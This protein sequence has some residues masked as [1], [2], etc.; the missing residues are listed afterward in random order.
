MGHFPTPTVRQTRPRIRFN[1]TFVGNFAPYLT[2]DPSRKANVRHNV[3]VQAKLDSVRAGPKTG[4]LL[5]S[6]K[7]VGLKP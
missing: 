3:N 2:W 5:H 6:V 7:R 1:P 4:G